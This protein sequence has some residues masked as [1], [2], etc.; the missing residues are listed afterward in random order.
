MPILSFSYFRIV[1]WLSSI[2]AAIAAATRTA[3]TTKN[4]MMKGKCNKKC[5]QPTVKDAD[6]RLVNSELMF[7]PLSRV[8]FI[9]KTFN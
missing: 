1:V 4:F 9:P 7:G 6:A 3:N 5:G 2:G 8:L